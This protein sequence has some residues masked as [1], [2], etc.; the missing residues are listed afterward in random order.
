MLPDCP[1]RPECNVT[2]TPSSK[3]GMSQFEFGYTHT[4]DYMTCQTS[5]LTLSVI[6]T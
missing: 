4:D 2:P 5:P 3:I 6:V 1:E